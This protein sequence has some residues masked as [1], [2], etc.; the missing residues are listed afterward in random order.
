MIESLSDVLALDARLLTGIAIAIGTFALLGSLFGL[1][2][3]LTTLPERVLS[4]QAQAIYRTAFAPYQI[5]LVAIA[6]LSLADLAIIYIYAPRWLDW[7]EIGLGLAVGILV[8]WTGSRIFKQFFDQYLL[9]AVIQSKRKINSELL[10]VGKVLAN[11]AIVVTVL[12]VFAQTHQ[13]NLFGLLASLGVGGLAI[14]FAAQKSLEQLLGG[15]VLYIDRPFVTDDYVGLDDGTFGRIES[16]GLR[17]TRIRTSGKGTVMVVPNNLLTESKV[18]NFTDARKIISIVYLRFY[19]A[20]PEDEKA[21]I[22]QVIL[23]STRD[24]VGIDPRS[25]EVTFNDTTDA[26]GQSFTQGQINLFVLGSGKFSME[27]RRQL[28]DSAKQNVSLQLK[29]YGIAFDLQERTT[30]VASPITI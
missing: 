30:N 4:P 13:I 22:R 25:T 10:V 1:Y 8:S 11:V 9:N 20:I 15:I 29:E 19:R 21:L 5:W 12:F 6:F 28:V 26:S 24:I 2:R 18:E 3:L 17:S 14:A 23:D 7:F 27:L 16:I